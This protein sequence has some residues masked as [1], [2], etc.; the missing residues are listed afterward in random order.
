[1]EPGDY[2][3][4][5][6]HC[7]SVFQSW[8]LVLGISFA[9]NADYQRTLDL[10]YDRDKLIVVPVPG[11]LYTSFRNEIISNPKVISAEGTM[12]YLGWGS[13]RR[14]VKDADKQLEVDVLDIGPG[15]AQTMGLRL[16]G[17]PPFRPDQGRC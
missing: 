13:Y 14:P 3:R 15:Y 17:R 12:N 10:G 7:N 9:K 11:D 2:L 16:T 6:W 4:S 5:F 1:M 8:L